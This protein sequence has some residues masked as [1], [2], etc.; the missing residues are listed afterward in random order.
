MGLFSSSSV[1]HQGTGKFVGRISLHSEIFVLN[2]PLITL[3]AYLF[4]NTRGHTFLWQQV[5][6]TPVQFTQPV[7]GTSTQFQ[8]T[9]VGDDKL[10][11]FYID[12]GTRFQIVNYI[13]VIAKPTDYI[14][15][16]GTSAP[17]SNIIGIDK[18]TQSAYGDSTMQVNTLFSMPYVTAPL[19]TMGNAFLSSNGATIGFYPP[20]VTLGLTSFTILQNS[21]NGYTSIG[22]IVPTGALSYTIPQE[23]NLGNKIKI[24]SVYYYNSVVYSLPLSVQFL[25]ETAAAVDVLGSVGTGVGSGTNANI[26]IQTTFQDYRILSNMQTDYITESIGVGV[27]NVNIGA[28]AITTAGNAGSYSVSSNVASFSYSFTNYWMINNNYADMITESIGVGAANNIYS[29]SFVASGV[30]MS[31]LG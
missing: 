12:Y 13:L 29:F 8:Q 9:S 15:T 16:I 10:F 6:G 2:E 27:L 31:S 19:N 20:S 7:N 22:N 21:G 14:A 11:A 26:N 18:L 23:I 5:S 25:N 24:G 17:V 4:G 3:T 28:N 30:G 1:Y